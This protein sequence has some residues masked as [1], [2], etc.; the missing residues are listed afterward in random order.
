MLTL[1]HEFLPQDT[2]NWPW[3]NHHPFPLWDGTLTKQEMHAIAVF[4]VDLLIYFDFGWYNEF[5]HRQ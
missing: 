3:I 1:K 4:F 5:P 2:E